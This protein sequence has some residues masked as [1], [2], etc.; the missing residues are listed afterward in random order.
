MKTFKVGGNRK[1][2]SY[3]LNSKTNLDP[4]SF[5][6]EQLINQNRGWLKKNAASK[7]G[8]SNKNKTSKLKEIA[9]IS[10]FCSR[11]Q[12]LFYFHKHL[13]FIEKEPEFT[14]EK[15]TLL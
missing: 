11:E 8:E 5:K 4:L 13:D 3:L 1:Y 2:S 14:K 10:F 12:K 7:I 6:N 15:I 9:I